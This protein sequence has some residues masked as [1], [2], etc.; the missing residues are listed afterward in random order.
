MGPP[1]RCNAAF[2]KDLEAADTVRRSQTRRKD[3]SALPGKRS[4]G[5]GRRGSSE[6]TGA[7]RRDRPRA[8]KSGES[9]AS[10]DT[11]GNPVRKSQSDEA[12]V[13][14]A[15]ESLRCHHSWKSCRNCGSKFVCWDK[16][17]SVAEFPKNAPLHCSIVSAFNL[18]K[19]YARCHG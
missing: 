3:K 1:H 4:G 10:Q 7:K 9:A 15:A 5:R 19:I 17:P 14:T 16:S 2:V 6:S 18:W 11:P 12:G 13:G 8:D